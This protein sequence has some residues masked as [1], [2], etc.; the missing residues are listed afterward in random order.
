MIQSQN[1]DAV[2]KKNLQHSKSIH[3]GLLTIGRKIQK[4][5]RPNCLHRQA[6]QMLPQ[7]ITTRKLTKFGFSQQAHDLVE[8]PVDK[9][10]RKKNQ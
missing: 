8:L 5:P 2:D 1:K 6:N 10:L 7:E 4:N 9:L 3:H